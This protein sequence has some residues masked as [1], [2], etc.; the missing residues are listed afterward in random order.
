MNTD[1]MILILGVT[2]SGKGKLA[3]QLA[4]NYG[5]EIISVDSMKVYRRMDIGTAKPP[6]DARRHIKH[7]LIDIREPGESFD[8]ATFLRVVDKSATEIRARNKPVIAVG[9]TA[10][11][12]KALLYGLFEGPGADPH[13]RKKIKNRIKKIGLKQL[14]QQLESIDPH[15]CRTIHPNDSRRIIRALEV[16]ELT[17]RP[18][19]S[20]QKQWP[21]SPGTTNR[22]Q[23]K[24]IGLKRGKAEENKRINLR[25][26][27]MIEKGL[28]EEV[29]ALLSEPKPL[30][31]QAASAI[32]YAEVT[33]Y[34]QNKMTLEDAVE[35]IKKNT[36]RLAKNQRTWFKT[37]TDTNWLNIEPDEKQEQVLKRT[38]LLIEKLSSSGR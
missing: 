37:F 7:H 2:A 17:G 32:G 35:Q 31:K 10:L 36:R 30:S 12:I 29:K 13:I 19:S 4:E 16:Y 23:W 9:G 28:V 5:A 1:D 6:P 20:L 14:Y 34:L 38:R 22:H 3:F 11:Y 25:A 27:Q 33:H 18:I 8:V 15:A 26:K 24:I 21:Q